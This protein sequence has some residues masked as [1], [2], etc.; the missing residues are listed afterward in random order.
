MSLHPSRLAVQAAGR[1]HT[2][3]MSAQAPGAC[4]M[5]GQHH[6]IGDPVTPFVPTD[7]FTDYPALRAKSS[8]II[9]GW[10]AATCN[11]IFTQKV[12]KTVICRDGIFPAAS[13]V[14]IAYW[15]LNP[16]DGPWMWVQGDQKKQHIIWRTP[17]NTSRDVYQV[18]NGEQ[19]L[20][21]RRQ[22]LLPAVEAARRLA[23]AASAGRKGAALKSPF[24][25]LSRDL[26]DP[27]HG[28]I[29]A[30]LHAKA[31]TDDAVATDVRQI[32][33]LTA[34]ELWA[35]TALLYAEPEA[36]RPQPYFTPSF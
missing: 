31:L 33:S 19:V 12:L 27:A 13:N 23:R 11:D 34:G 4:A 7:S 5:C 9:C 3:V 14:H 2:G 32:Q 15:L 35:L 22:R 17:V 36:T 28:C 20:T 24:V 21:V 16:P 26:D 29:R 25:R 18:R 8:R 30:D 10:C 1:D 6:A